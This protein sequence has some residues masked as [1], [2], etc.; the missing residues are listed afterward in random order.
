MSRHNFNFERWANTDPSPKLLHQPQE[1]AT[2]GEFDK[3]NARYLT[4]KAPWIVLNYILC[5]RCITKVR[6]G[7]TLSRRW[8]RFWR[9]P[10]I[11]MTPVSNI[12]RPMAPPSEFKVNTC[13][14]GRAMMEAMFPTLI[15][16]WCHH[17]NAWMGFSCKTFFVI[18]IKYG[19]WSKKCF[20]LFHVDFLV[21][22]TPTNTLFRTNNWRNYSIQFIIMIPYL[23]SNLDHNLISF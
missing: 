9:T 6:R 7:Q 4:C 23:I 19:A 13:G 15:A 21:R 17:Q 10:T 11:L 3:R 22:I 12:D 18:G 5:L 8:H 20:G 16:R 1:N 14:E 2:V